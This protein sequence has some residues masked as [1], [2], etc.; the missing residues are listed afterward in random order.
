MDVIFPSV[1]FSIYVRSGINLSSLTVLRE[2]LSKFRF[3][4]W[5]NAIVHSYYESCTELL[6]VEIIRHSGLVQMKGALTKMVGQ[7]GFEPCI[8][9]SSF[10]KTT[11]TVHYMQVAI[12]F[13]EASEN[14]PDFLDP[15]V[16]KVHVI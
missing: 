15:C 5:E 3:R 11:L 1:S 2:I 10:I 13:E 4:L 6:G 14:N 16:Y 12:L 8:F 9:S 7:E